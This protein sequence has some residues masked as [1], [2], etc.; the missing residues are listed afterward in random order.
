MEVH[1]VKFI[2]KNQSNLKYVEWMLGD[3]CNYSCSY[4]GYNTGEKKWLDLE[5]YKS[6]ITKIVEDTKPN[7]VSFQFTGGEPTLYR[8]FQ[9]ILKHVKEYD[10]YTRIISNG[11][12]TIRWW[13]EL[14][15]NNYVDGLTLS[16]H[17]TQTNDYQHITNVAN[18]FRFTNTWV[19]IVIMCP[20]SHFDLCVEAWNYIKNNCYVTI[21]L[22]QV[23]DDQIGMSKYTDMQKKFL[24]EN[25]FTHIKDPEFT[26]P[27][28]PTLSQQM[29][30]YYNDGS[31]I[32]KPAQ[33]FV[34]SDQNNFS[35]WQCDA[36]VNLLRVEQDI[37]Q[38]GICGVGEKWSITEEKPFR[39]T[40]VT[41]TKNSCNCLLDLRQ[42][43]YLTEKEI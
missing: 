20:P 39:N 24:L 29:I 37:A 4:C 5:Q 21:T 41:C 11:S 3:T 1:P 22:M 36:G 12:R 31:I 10:S 27:T 15:H 6:L 7:K 13:E 26:K 2:R 9:E 34:L 19:G 38:R 33:Y 18:L 43:K 42:N 30:M 8:H 28:N 35:G 17:P 32:E 40:K 25:F 16:F 23:N 14:V